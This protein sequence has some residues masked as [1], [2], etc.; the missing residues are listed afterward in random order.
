[1]V[2]NF[3]LVVVQPNQDLTGPLQFLNQRMRDHVNK[4]LE[5]SRIKS[6]KY[7]SF[8]ILSIRF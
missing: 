4:T 5:I 2:E 3:I 1:M 6:S 7:S 8:L